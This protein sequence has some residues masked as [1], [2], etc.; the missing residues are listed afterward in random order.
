MRLA[1]LIPLVA[2]ALST[3]AMASGPPTI[4][5][6]TDSASLRPYEHNTLD[7]AVNSVRT[8][9]AETGARVDAVCIVASADRVGSSAYNLRLSR[10][11]G[12]LVRRELITRG[13]EPGFVIVR[14]LGEERPLVETA[15]EVAEAS[16]R[17]ATIYIGSEPC[18]SEN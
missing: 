1:L 18:T 2:A 4:W 9:Q 7:Y 5:F 17:Y 16:N 8:Y 3:P 10:R 13:F 15:D 11:R 12:E 14:A 6:A